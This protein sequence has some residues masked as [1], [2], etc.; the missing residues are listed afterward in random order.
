MGLFDRAGVNRKLYFIL[1]AACVL[2]NIG[3]LPYILSLGSIS[4]EQ[5]PPLP[6]PIL[7]SAMIV[8]ATIFFSIA[9]FAGLFL[10]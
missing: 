7:L 9:I 10:G 5:L 2:S 4:G 6:F 8:Q 3:A 1:L